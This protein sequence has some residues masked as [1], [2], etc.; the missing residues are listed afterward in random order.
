MRIGI[1][2]DHRGFKLKQKLAKYLINRGYNVVDY[3]TDSDKSVDYPDYAIKIGK[4]IQKKEIDLGLVICGT[5]IG[6]SIATNKLKGIRCAKVCSVREAKMAKSHNDANVIAINGNMC[7]LIA[8]RIVNAFIITDFSNEER[9]I[10]R[11]NKII[12]IEEEN[13]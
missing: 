1:A 12:K 5:G 10:R 8:K 2:N 3:G 9:H 7:F 6:I 4:G 13:L 11:I